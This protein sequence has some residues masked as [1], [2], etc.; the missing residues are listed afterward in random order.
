MGS[1]KSFP[2]LT[3]HGRLALIKMLLARGERF[4]APNRF[5]KTHV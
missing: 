5:V 2:H 1:Y 4:E 3:N